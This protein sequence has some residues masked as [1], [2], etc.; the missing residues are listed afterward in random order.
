MESATRTAEAGTPGC[1]IRARRASHSVY[2][3]AGLLLAVCAA[4]MAH[5]TLRSVGAEFQIS[6]GS[7]ALQTTPAVAMD[8]TGGMVVVW[9]SGGNIAGRRYDNAGQALGAEF[10]ANTNTSAFHSRPAV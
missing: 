6:T 5:A 4:P 8:P 2:A 1:L 7:A 9:T 10:Q 3:V